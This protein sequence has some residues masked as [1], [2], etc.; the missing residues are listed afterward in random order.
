M[1]LPK[2]L[3]EYCEWTWQ[4]GHSSGNRSRAVESAVEVIRRSVGL[5]FPATL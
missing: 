1:E 4:S 2:V 3:Y 5:D